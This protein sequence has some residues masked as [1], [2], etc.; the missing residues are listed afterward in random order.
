MISIETVPVGNA[1][2]AGD[3]QMHGTF[4]AV[5]YAYR[6]GKY[7]VTNSQYAAF[8]N[9]VADTDTYFLYN[10]LM[11][12]TPLG[13]ITRSGES[14]S[15]SYTVKPN[16]GDKPVNHV[17]FWDAA[18]FTNWL[19]NGQGNSSTETGAYTLGVTNSSGNPL[20]GASVTRNANATWFIPT[21]NEW[22]KAAYHKNDGMTGNYFTFPTSSDV[23][24]TVA[25]ANVVGDISNPGVNVANYLRGADWNDENGNV[26]TIGSAGT[27]SAS[28][29]GT[30][31]QG[32]NVLEWN[33]TPFRGSRD[34]RGGDWRSSSS[35]PLAAGTK[36]FYFGGSGTA[37]QFDYLGFRVATTLVADV[38]GD[39]NADGIVNAADYAV[40]RDTRGSTTNL[41]ADGSG[42]GTVDTADFSFWRAR[43]GNTVGAASSADVAVPEPTMVELGLIVFAILSISP[44][45]IRRTVAA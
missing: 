7:E 1:G 43:F 35:G 42:N 16:M 33:E 34:Q 41:A 31:D 15:Y 37:Q 2:N 28:P 26:T 20:D 24:P 39:Y 13:G 9:E 19:H 29:Y 40:W 11:D 3:V 27:G 25:T 45:R 18:R 23:A 8:L 30:F 21:E 17:S 36:I 5:P 38:E 32:G 12:V 22:H 6:I 44:G 14:G 4:G 10:L